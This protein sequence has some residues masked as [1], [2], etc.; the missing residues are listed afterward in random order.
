MQ[1]SNSGGLGVNGAVWT[2]NRRMYLAE[3]WDLLCRCW[4]RLETESQACRV[5]A[6]CGLG[7]V[8]VSPVSS[9]LHGQ[10]GGI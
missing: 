1:V 6:S 4:W 8:C 2:E 10:W 3:L 7:S 5:S 9:T